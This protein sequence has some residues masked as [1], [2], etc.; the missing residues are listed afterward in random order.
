M[1]AAAVRLGARLVQSRE[2]D[3]G[4]PWLLDARTVSEAALEALAVHDAG[5][6]LCGDWACLAWQATRGSGTHEDGGNRLRGRQ[7]SKPRD[8][9]R[10]APKAATVL[11]PFPDTATLASLCAH[12]HTRS[13]RSTS[14]GG[15]HDGREEVSTAL[16]GAPPARLLQHQDRPGGSPQTTAGA[17]GRPARPT[18]PAA[19]VAAAA[20]G[21]PS[22]R[23]PAPAGRWRATRGWSRRSRRCTC[24]PAARRP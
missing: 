17:A 23:C 19:A 10:G 3:R 14:V 4:A 5:A 6:T 18:P 11:G 13:W 22:T 15:L 16:I 8:T 24:A 12:R 9:S 20:A 21:L 1:P 2:Q 7:A